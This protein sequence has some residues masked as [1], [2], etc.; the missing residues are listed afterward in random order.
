M[1]RY[2]TLLLLVSMLSASAV[3]HKLTG[4][5]IGT[6]TS[7]D[8]STGL[9]STTVNTRFNAFD[10]DLSTYFASYDR[11]SVSETEIPRTWVGLDLGSKHVISKVGWSPRD[12]GYGEQRVQLGLFEGAN[13]P[14]FTDAIPIYLIPDKGTIGTISYADV[15]CSRGFR[16]VR[17]L[18]P[19]NARC[20]IAEVE[21]YGEEG[22]G[23][24]SHLYTVS[25]LPTVVI[26]TTGDF[27]GRD[28]VDKVTD[29]TSSITI[30][31]RNDDGTT[32]VLCQPGTTRLRGNNSMTHPKK[33]YRIKF[34][35]KQKVLDA[36]AKA[37]KW[38]LINTYG[39]KTILRN[40]ISFEIARRLE[41]DYVPYCRLVDVIYNGDYKGTYQLCDQIEINKNRVNIT[42]MEVD[43][44]AGEAI[45]GGYLLE[46]DAYASQEGEEH[47]F[48]SSSGIPVT[49]K[50]PDESNDLSLCKSYI[51]TYWNFME[52]AVMQT[53]RASLDQYM[54]VKSYCKIFLVGELT[55][56][57]D[58]F[59]SM[60][61]TKERNDALFRFGPVWDYELTFNNDKRTKDYF[62]NPVAHTEWL[63]EFDDGNGNHTLKAGTMGDF[64]KKMLILFHAGEL[65]DVWKNGYEK[66]NLRASSLNAYVD[67]L[68]EE[69]D[70]S[71]KLNFIRWPILSKKVHMNF[72]A[73]G[74]YEKEVE[75][76]KS[77]ITT[78]VDWMNAKL[79]YK[80]A[81]VD[82]VISDAL[83]ELQ[84][85]QIFNMQG[86][87]LYQGDEMPEL[88]P[89][90][91][92]VR[93]GA[94]SNKVMIT[95]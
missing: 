14:D 58:T 79:G 69:I 62:F 60:Y 49:I 51:S 26:Y 89:G 4:T 88:E 82:G 2:I 31:S 20:N 7:V 18:G 90:V 10:G 50:S 22:E 94:F 65:L 21:F 11:S 86:V 1:N 61:V 39:D 92:I 87:L 29:Y 76:V 30:I 15:D 36:P 23:D 48:T 40:E 3:P 28:P 64:A 6:E 12:D 19:D 70:Q 34:D 53:S 59:W 43:D 74:S 8:Y 77:Y 17:Y 84:P 57:S 33:P 91:Y 85:K 32:A 9:P 47:Y 67:K 37:K 35:S 78:R 5:V 41:M 52:K 55:G 42:E 66:N 24:D 71:Q 46:I 63:F 25:N 75:F 83:D 95:R 45:T 73:L 56:N 27:F 38:T 54:D 13:S 68:A 80:P 44:L 81:G 16:Y 72:Q 93:Q